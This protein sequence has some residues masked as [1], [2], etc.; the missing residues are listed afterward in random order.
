MFAEGGDVAQAA[1]VEAS[2]QTLQWL[3]TLAFD[4]QGGLYVTANRLQRYITGTMDF[5]GASGSNIFVHRFDVGIRGY[6]QGP[7]ALTP[8]PDGDKTALIASTVTAGVVFIAALLFAAK[9]LGGCSRASLLS[10]SDVRACP[11]DLNSTFVRFQAM[12]SPADR[13]GRYLLTPERVCPLIA[14]EKDVW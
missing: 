12:P 5:T 10:V 6:I 14:A 3:D 1:V 11:L 9:M 8:S 13:F 2:A 7:C 4:E